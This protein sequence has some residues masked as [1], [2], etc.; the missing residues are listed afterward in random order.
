SC[1]APP[2]PRSAATR[3]VGRART[4]GRG[5]RW[6]SMIPAEGE[7]LGMVH[8][9]VRD[10]LAAGPGDKIEYSTWAEER[11]ARERLVGGKRR[12]AMQYSPMCAVPY[13][14]N[15][16]A[17]TVELVRSLG[18]DVLSSAELVQLFEARW[19]E[20]QRD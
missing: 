14:S 18:V 11:G 7:P 13:V 2:R 12:I 19:T 20:E 16:D 17:G 10:E 3:L 8:R 1:S 6:F 4:S 5:G 15:V 9:I